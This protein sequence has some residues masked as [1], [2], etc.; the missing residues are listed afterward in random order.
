MNEDE[1]RWYSEFSINPLQNP[2]NENKTYKARTTILHLAASRG[3]YQI[4]EAY[5]KLYPQSAYGKDAPKTNGMTARMPVEIALDK[6]QDKLSH[7]LM[8]NMSNQRYPSL[9]SLCIFWNAI[10]VM[11]RGYFYL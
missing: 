2:Y 5:L 9:L 10:I 8:K 11:Y 3:L 7:L 1:E 4:A 6:Q